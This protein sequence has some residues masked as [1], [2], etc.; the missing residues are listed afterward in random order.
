M[1]RMG[2]NERHL[3]GLGII[4]RNNRNRHDIHHRGKHRVHGMERLQKKENMI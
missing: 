1:Q 2:L 4:H 3:A